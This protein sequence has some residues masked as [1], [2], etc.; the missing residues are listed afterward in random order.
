[1]RFFTSSIKYLFIFVPV[2]RYTSCIV[3]MFLQIFIGFSYMCRNGPA[4][5][6]PITGND[7]TTGITSSPGERPGVFS[8][9]TVSPLGFVSCQKGSSRRRRA[10]F[11]IYV[12]GWGILPNRAGSFLRG[13]SGSRRRILQCLKE[14]WREKNNAAAEGKSHQRRDRA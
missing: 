4:C 2:L 7:R 10:F 6:Y 5:L 14:I 12:S 13:F 1:M 3:Y 11:V 9:V 8:F